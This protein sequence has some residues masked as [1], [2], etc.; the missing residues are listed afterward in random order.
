[1]SEALRK[2]HESDTVV[3]LKRL[4]TSRDP[5]HVAAV[6]SANE[7]LY[8]LKALTPGAVHVDSALANLSVQYK[9]EDYI[10]LNLMPLV[11]AAKLSDKFFV[12]DKRT[13]L[14]APDDSVGTRSTPNE[15][16]ENRTTDNYS[17]TPYALMDFVDEL[18]L[19]N[20][21]A[22]L[23]EMVDLVAAVNDVLDLR[24]EMRIAT[25][26]TTAANYN[27]AQV[28]TLSGASCWDSASGGDPIK[29]I[30]DAAAANWMGYGKT[31]TKAFCSIDVWKVISRHPKILDLFKYGGTAPGLAKPQQFCDYFGFDEM[32]IGRAWNDTANEGQTASYARI[33]GKCF[34]VINVADSPG[35][36]SAGFGVTFRFGEKKT[37]Q[38]FEPKPG[39]AGG[40]YAK[41]GLSEDHKITAK[42]SG[43]LIDTV[44]A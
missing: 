39:V 15:L 33:W 25:K 40:Y 21:D 31:R 2:A 20:Q 8:R 6:R 43:S 10:G 23:D 12:Y 24:E 13:R 36:R 41:C 38:W 29:N 28:T 30:Q 32:H 35:P 17:C 4:L 14:A 16:S 3:R 42:D 37:T 44:I 7:A 18:S 9:N 27:S 22:P 5:K 34:G 19:A 1:M 26:L 11:K